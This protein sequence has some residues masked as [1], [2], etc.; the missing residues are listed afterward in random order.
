[1]NEAITPA[2]RQLLPG[3]LDAVRSLQVQADDLKKTMVVDGIEVLAA[4]IL[5]HART[6]GYAP[7]VTWAQGLADAVE[8]LDARA[9]AD[10]LDTLHGEIERM[11]RFV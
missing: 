4:K 5:G 2:V 9:M 11:Q 8:M 1:M 3:L 10:S 7:L 6:A